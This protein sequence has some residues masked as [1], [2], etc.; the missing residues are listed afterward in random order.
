MLAYLIRRLLIAIPVLLGILAMTFVLV[1]MLP[2]DP[3]TALLTPEEMQGSADLIEKRRADLGL[4]R[5]LPIQ[6]VAWLGELLDGNLGVS[7][8][9]KVPV[10][11]MI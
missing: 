2:G 7:F 11:E 9:R 8:H 4:D 1:H 5:P 6:Y 3:V 10:T